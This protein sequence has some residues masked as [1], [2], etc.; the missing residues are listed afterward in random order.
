MNLMEDFPTQPEQVAEALRQSEA[1]YRRIV[2]NAPGMVY[3]FV[4]HADGTVAFPYVS[5]GSLALFGLTPQSIMDDALALVR[6]IHPADMPG[7]LQSVETS[8][9][10]LGEWKWE[11]RFVLA[12]GETRWIGAA[13]HPE[14]E[15]NGDVLWDGL[16]IDITPTKTAEENLRRQNEY[17]AALHETTLALM[18]RLDLEDL[19][20]HLVAR[21]GR[22]LNA[23]HG[24]IYLVSADSETMEMRVGIGL[25]GAFHGH[26]M[27]RGEGVAGRVWETGQTLIVN[28]YKSWRGH[29]T[30][31][32][33]TPLRAVLAAPLLS[34]NQVVGV[35]G[36]AYDTETLHAFG[37]SESELLNRFAQLASLALDNARLYTALQAELHER[38]KVEAALLLAKEE[39]ET[40]N[41]TKSQFLANMSHELRTPLNAIIGYSEML[42]EDAADAGQED[43]IPDLKKI[44]SAGKH[45]LA[46]INDVLD[47][48]KIE[49]GRMELYVETFD[50]STM[51]REVVSTIEPLVQK[52]QNRLEVSCPQDIGTIRADLTKVRQSLFNLISNAAKFTENGRISLAVERE[53]QGGE[54][55]VFRVSD[56]GI[57]MTE[58]QTARVFQAFAQADA[59]TTR[60]YGGTGLGLAITKRFC[61]MMGGTISLASV[62][63]QGTTFTIRLPVAPVA[64]QTTGNMPALMGEGEL[65]STLENTGKLPTLLV[66]DDDATT[67]DLMREALLQEGFQVEC[68]ASGEEGLRLAR[69]IRPLAV[70]LDVMMP[71]MDGWAVLSKMKA[72][73]ELAHIPV[74][75]VT[76]AD[77]ANVGFALGAADYLT[78]P[79]EPLRLAAILDKFRNRNEAKTVLVV[80]DDV[81]TRQMLRQMLQKAGWKV[82]E[83]ENGRIGLQRVAENPPGLILLDLMMP[84]MDGFEFTAE[85]HKRE[86][87]SAIP[88]IVITAKD[89]T[90]EDRQRLEGRVTQMLQKGTY[91]HQALVGQIRE[92]L[93]GRKPENANA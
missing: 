69:T 89:I 50:V 76:L 71:H 31:F 66:I 54:W 56:T 75:M 48:S 6:L 65:P 53:P 55:I 59:S 32:D 84:E 88:I 35:I 49:A 36:L 2:A 85:M 51:L 72:D 61:E 57:G 70:T 1:R 80:E 23:L 41:R 73:P 34:G 15:P 28:D 42:Q 21:A 30:D 27:R 19:L 8:A 39:A 43:F 20:E 87:W 92:L 52:N 38:K 12:S 83:A 93:S 63:G 10:T 60:K 46:L 44:N 37:P 5:T 3:Q 16:L 18:Q 29:V 81:P 33:A 74:V 45:L 40:A 91:N 22:M 13:S 25:A 62:L 86:D 17:F 7:F 4:R 78:K 77:E 58:A 67:R 82:Q 11:G 9:H 79:V 14:Q 24:Y 47:L 64:E 26:Q 68:A 90:A